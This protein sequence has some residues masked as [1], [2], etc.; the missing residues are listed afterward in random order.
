M[1]LLRIDDSY[2][3]RAARPEGLEVKDHANRII[4]LEE[5]L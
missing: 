3:G 4:G 2:H 1:N 5:E